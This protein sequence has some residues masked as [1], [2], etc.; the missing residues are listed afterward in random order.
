MLSFNF[1]GKSDQSAYCI[2]VSEQ[3]YE[4]LIQ[5]DFGLVGRS[6][7]TKI[8]LDGEEEELPLV[9]LENPTRG[10]LTAYFNGLV[11]SETGQ[12]LVE[13]DAGVAR[14]VLQPRQYRM[15]KLLELLDCVK[16]SSWHYLQR[17]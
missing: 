16:D 3:F 11:L 13:L 14:E 10:M 17:V 6:H 9:R 2:Q 15:K 5:A 12:M 8:M 1:Y 4:W 7:P